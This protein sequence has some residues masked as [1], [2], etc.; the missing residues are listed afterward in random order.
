[1]GRS[2][3]VGRRE[4]IAVRLSPFSL[5]S[6]LGRV[7]GVDL[8]FVIADY[9]FVGM[10]VSF[11]AESSFRYDRKWRGRSLAMRGNVVRAKL[12][13]IYVRFTRE[14]DCRWN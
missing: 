3:C 2:P 12:G 9:D 5:W 1:M 6:K 4:L 10:T 13:I 14:I 7:I 11:I 8:R